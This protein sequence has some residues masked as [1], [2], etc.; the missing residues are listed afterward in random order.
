ML[1][2]IDFVDQ[3]VILGKE[4]NSELLS[5]QSLHLKSKYAK[6]LLSLLAVFQ[7]SIEFKTECNKWVQ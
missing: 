6:E 1:E 2:L 5:E 3:A 7:L 4:T